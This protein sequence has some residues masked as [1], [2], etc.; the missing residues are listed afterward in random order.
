MIRLYLISTP[1]LGALV[2]GLTLIAALALL[3]LG[4]FL[5]RRFP[6][7]GNEVLFCFLGATGVIYALVLGLLAVATWDALKSV[8]DA[9]TREAL[10]AEKLYWDLAGYAQPERDHLRGMI[11]EYVREVIEVEWPRQKRG[12]DVREPAMLVDMVESWTRVEPVTE[13][14]KLIHAE[15][16][17][18][19]NEMLSF[20]RM[21][22]QAKDVAL[23]S[24]LWVVVLLGGAVNLFL[25]AMIRPEKRFGLTPLVMALA[26][27]IGLMIFEIVAVDHP[28]WGEVSIQATPY[29]DVLRSFQN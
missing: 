19:L 24:V 13:G 15:A 18:E 16:L 4:R 26:A 27:M 3:G 28:L 22:R 21:R 12:L 1:A 11:R 20:G 7:P 14:Q 5:A 23:P 10:E 8:E 25:A 6:H 9:C 2:I 17:G 29:Q